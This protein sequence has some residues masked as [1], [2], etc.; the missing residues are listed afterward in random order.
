VKPQPVKLST[1]ITT[2]NRHVQRAITHLRCG[3]VTADGTRTGV[4]SAE[5]LNAVW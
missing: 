4:F 5:R 3:I 2:R 1:I